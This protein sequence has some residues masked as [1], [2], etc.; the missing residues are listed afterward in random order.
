MK[1]LLINCKKITDSG[2]EYFVMENQDFSQA[3]LLGRTGLR[4]GRLGVAAGYGAPAKAFEEAFHR[5]CNYFYWGSMRKSNMREA[6]KNICAQG[7]REQLVIVIQSYSR[8]A[9]LMESFFEKALRTL[10]LDHVEILL[11]GWHNSRPNQKLIDKALAM[12][13]KGLFRFLALSGHNRKLFPELA[14]EGLFDLFHVRYN[15]AH[16]GAEQETFPFLPVTDG[17]GLVTYTATRWGRLLNPDKMPP[18]VGPPS[19]S[20]CYRFSLSNRA[21]DVCLSGPKDEAQMKEALKTLELG[22]LNPEEIKRMRKIGDYLH[23]D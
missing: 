12:K 13:E 16:R 9:L 11:M 7:R 20:D 17:P 19:A 3:T 5:G 10:A 15:A 6:I 4:V 8:S 2:Q 14:R 22:P 1:L 18:G 21:V 23:G